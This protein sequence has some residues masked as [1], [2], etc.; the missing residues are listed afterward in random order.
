M[1]QT[2]RA[3]P[4]ALSLGT[5]M[6]PESRQA[7]PQKEQLAVPRREVKGQAELGQVVTRGQA[8]GEWVDRVQAWRP[9][10]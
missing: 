8:T 6:T 10:E 9:G 4:G 7:L 1:N 2:D 5:A 3:V